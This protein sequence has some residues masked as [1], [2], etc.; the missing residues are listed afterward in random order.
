MVVGANS[1]QKWYHKNEYGSKG[2]I[3]INII[4]C[5]SDEDLEN[6]ITYYTKDAFVAQF[7]LATVPFIGEK[8]WSPYDNEI[9][10]DCYTV[11]FCKSNVFVRLFLG[12][13]DR[14]NDELAQTAFQISKKIETK[15]KSIK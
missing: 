15:I 4:I 10:E 5:T 1:F 2:M 13:Q 7:K 11:M 14:K 9:G 8:S 3:E 12:I 6:T